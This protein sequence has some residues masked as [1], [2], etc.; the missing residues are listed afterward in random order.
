MSKKTL[1]IKGIALFIFVLFI[2]MSA[3]PGTSGKLAVKVNR[4][5]ITSQNN[6]LQETFFEYSP[7]EQ[8]NKTFGGNYSDRGFYCE[9]TSNEGYILTGHTWSYGNGGYDV[10]LIRT[11]ADGN[12]EWNKTF[13]GENDDVG[14]S[15]HFTID[16]GYIIVGSTNSFG[17]G[18]SDV[19]LIKTDAFGNEEWNKTFGKEYNDWGWSVNKTI[20]NGYVITGIIEPYEEDVRDLWLIKTDANGN[21]EWNKTFGG[22]ENDYGYSV[23]QISDGG[24]L[25]LGETNSFGSGSGD[26]WLIK[27]DTNGTEE[28]NKTFG[29]NDQD[30]GISMQ[31][32]ENTGYIITGVTRSFGLDSGDVWLIKTDVFGNEQWNRTFGG[33]SYDCG[34]SI[35]TTEDGGF[36]IC[37]ITETYGA[38]EE[39]VWLIK[40]DSSG[41]E[42]WNKTFGGTNED[43]GYSVQQ[44]TDGGYIIG[45]CTMSYGVGDMDVWLIKVAAKAELKLTFFFGY[46][47]NIIHMEDFIKFNAQNLFYL[48]FSPLN[49]GGYKSSEEIIAKQ[50]LALTMEGNPGI[51][52]GFYRT[53]L[54]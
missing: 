31:I 54:L 9:Q 2:M 14:I 29:G 23:Q 26:A 24:Y 47:T 5:N 6:S 12:E 18:N 4:K 15:V 46:V 10:W 38:G 28:W 13:G 43:W 19:W 30:A 1:F 34:A 21:E 17:A 48:V 33:T 3:I 35:D 41:N 25:I 20:D 8:W 7:S 27:T 40:T 36:I 39:D 37:A 42:Q 11:D 53:S 32:V 44:T 52:L 51:I 16:D 50:V 49:F 45:G 22:V